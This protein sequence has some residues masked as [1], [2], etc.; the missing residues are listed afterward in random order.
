MP[1]TMG[2]GH[3]PTVPGMP[4][5]YMMTHTHRQLEEYLGGLEDEPQAVAHQ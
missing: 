3:I 2:K 5:M 1:P 4:V